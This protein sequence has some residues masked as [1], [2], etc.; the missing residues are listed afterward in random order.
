[1][2]MPHPVD[3]TAQMLDCFTEKYNLPVKESYDTL[4]IGDIIQELWVYSKSRELLT[5]PDDN[6]YRVRELQDVQNNIE[7]MFH[8]L[9]G[10]IP[11]ED[12]KQLSEAAINVFDGGIFNDESFNKF[13]EQFAKNN[14]SP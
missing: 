1:M 14:P 10:K 3:V 9:E 11:S 5:D 13:V 8:S 12:T 2:F 7:Q 4:P 6:D